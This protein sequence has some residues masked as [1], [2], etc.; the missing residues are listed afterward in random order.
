MSEKGPLEYESFVTDNTKLDKE[1]TEKLEDNI[2][3]NSNNNTIEE[4][5]NPVAVSS[6]RKYSKLESPNNN[7]SSS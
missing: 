5:H 6:K 1:N 4:A 7:S 2:L 3:S